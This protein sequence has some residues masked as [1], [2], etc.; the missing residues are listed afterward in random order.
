M[1]FRIGDRVAVYVGGCEGV[2]AAKRL[3][4]ITSVD[5]TSPQVKVQ[6][7]DSGATWWAHGKQCRRL[8]KKER[9]RVWIMPHTLKVEAGICEKPID[10][11]VEFVEVK[12]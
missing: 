8:I 6:Y 11:W 1:T 4:T 9:R 2:P 12:P 10:G 7:D 5:I 3:G